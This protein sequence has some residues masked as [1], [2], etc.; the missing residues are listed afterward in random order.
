VLAGLALAGGLTIGRRLAPEAPDPPVRRFFLPIEASE[1]N[2]RL[3]DARISPDGK[4]IAYVL[5][6]KLYLRDFDALQA[7]VIEE[8]QGVN[9]SFW[10]PDSS[11]I[12]YHSD[13]TLW[14]VP[15]E[16]GKP[17]MISQVGDV[18]STTWGAEQ[19]IFFNNFGKGVSQVSARGGE[20]TVT[21]PSDDEVHYH[22]VAALPG[23]RGLVIVVHGSA[24][25]DTLA[26]WA[27][28]ELVT[29]LQI[30]EAEIADPI[31]AAGGHILFSRTRRNVGV[32]ALPFSIERLEVTGDPF[33][34]VPQGYEASASDDGTL[35]CT[36]AGARR[37]AELAWLD[38]SGEVQGTI[39]QPQDVIMMP[40]LSPDGTRVAVTGQ[41]N[42][43]WDIW[44]HD[45]ERGTKT[46]LTFADGFDGRPAWSAD[47]KSVLFFNGKSNEI[48]RVAADGSG[49]PES[50]I[51]GRSPTLSADNTRMVFERDGEETETDLWTL[52]LGGG[53]DPTV[54]LQTD[55]D[56]HSPALSP[57]GRFVAYVSDVSGNEE[58]YVKQHPGGHGRW[59]A[60]V[61]G[62]NRPG[63]SPSGDGLYFIGGTN[64]I[65]VSFSASPNVV[66]G[67]PEVVAN[68]TTSGFFPW[69]SPTLA[70]D[71]RFIVSRR[72]QPED[73]EERPDQGIHVVE[74]WL[75][76]FVSN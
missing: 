33:L 73:E 38:A 45:I 31:Y 44:I 18:N 47:G 8:S 60:S 49:E 40:A 22:D 30:D 54:F 70:P 42:T 52:D 3:S 34:A 2:S 37:E 16:G 68:G 69:A 50:I 65:Q 76:D 36:D 28:G 57:D 10:S 61:N 4:T 1:D 53:P 48:Y 64:L 27:G 6:G 35:I 15:V 20:A 7:R 58:V 56:E 26:L 67:A 74:N 17:T 25:V 41:E 66:L 24:S 32:W 21:I 59:Q 71:G 5:E 75:A 43:E 12:G 62:G 39:G 23:G 14:R 46:P 11:Q 72:V 29:L 63:W 51:E 9:G 55:A 19:T 13:R